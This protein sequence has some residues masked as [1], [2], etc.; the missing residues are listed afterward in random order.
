MTVSLLA[1]TAPSPSVAFVA[2]PPVR[3]GGVAPRTAP[4]RSPGGPDVPVE[5]IDAASPIAAE[6]T[7]STGATRDHF[8]AV[9][10]RPPARFEPL[11]GPLSPRPQRTLLDAV[12]E[13][14]P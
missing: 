8:P 2:S 13:W 7:P 14:A 12:R 3:A 9:R 1:R 5:V 6:A 10:V 11:V 4:S